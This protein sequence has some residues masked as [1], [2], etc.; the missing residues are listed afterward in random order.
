[1]VNRG[2]FMAFGV[3][4]KMKTVGVFILTIKKSLIN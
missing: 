3:N 4:E 1:M 2:G